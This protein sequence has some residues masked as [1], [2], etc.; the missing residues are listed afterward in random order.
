M[1]TFLE[2][3]GRK[4][5]KR[6]EFNLAENTALMSRFSVQE[7]GFGRRASRAKPRE[8]VHA[9]LKAAVAKEQHRSPF[10]GVIERADLSGEALLFS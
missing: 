9:L 1:K 5:A 4:A 6:G 7:F 2:R 10:H 8:T 3:N